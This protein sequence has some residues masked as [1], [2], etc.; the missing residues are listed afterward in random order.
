MDL[1]IV[2]NF[3]K[4][5]EKMR[6]LGLKYR[7]NSGSDIVIG[8]FFDVDCP[9][10][11]RMHRECGDSILSL[12]REGKVDLYYLDFPVHKGSEK[13]HVLIRRIFQK[14]PELFIE[15]LRKIYSSQD[16]KEFVESAK[17]I[18]LPQ[19]EIDQVMNC[20]KFGK[21][22]G[23]RGTPTLLIGIKSKNIAIVVEGYWGKQAVEKLIE[24]AVNKDKDLERL[25]TLLVLI[26]NVREYPPRDTAKVKGTTTTESS[27]TAQMSSL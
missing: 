27:T 9:A 16:G 2:T 7:E 22:L 6:E 18:D 10:C 8:I 24:K 23:V 21:E 12:A 25:I 15:T 3:V 19:S 11:A 4:V 5:L 13:A 1:Y 20:K 17:N 26:G 14:N